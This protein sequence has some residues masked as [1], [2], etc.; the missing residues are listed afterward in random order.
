LAA[1]ATEASEWN[2]SIWQQML[3]ATTPQKIS[4]T[5]FKKEAFDNEIWPDGRAKYVPGEFVPAFQ[6]VRE[7]GLNMIDASV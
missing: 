2:H 5:F 1:S 3:A 7:K 6:S 4:K